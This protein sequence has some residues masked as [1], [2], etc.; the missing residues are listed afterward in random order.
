MKTTGRPSADKQLRLS[1]ASAGRSAKRANSNVGPQSSPYVTVQRQ[2]L[3]GMFGNAI[4][5]EARE[6]V[7][8][9]Q[10][11]SRPAIGANDS[12]LSDNLRSGIESLSGVSLDGVN[13]HYNSTRPAALSALAYT[14]GNDIH[15]APGQ[16]RHLPHEAW[17]VVQQRQGRVVPTMQ[18]RGV[19]I[20]D[21][22]AL[23]READQMG[24]AAAQMKAGPQRNEDANAPGSEQRS[25]PGRGDPGTV[26]PATATHGNVAQLERYVKNK[27]SKIH[28]HLDIGKGDHLMIFGARYNLMGKSGY[29]ESRVSEAQEALNE[30]ADVDDKAACLEELGNLA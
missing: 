21:D 4:T 14:Q 30:A 10:G 2:Q 11:E 15:V 24:A 28:L 5:G 8:A 27:A 16:E 26:S 25:L 18:M 23:E 7:N 22:A 17:H 13:V 29:S 9:L 20:N 1:N 19:S 3:Q 6:E 12:G